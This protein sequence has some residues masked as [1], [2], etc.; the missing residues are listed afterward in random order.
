MSSRG[1]DHL[2][3]YFS[4]ISY[5]GIAAG[6]DRHLADR[7]S[8]DHRVLYVDP[9][10]S[11]LARLRNSNRRD[12]PRGPVLRPVRPGLFRCTPLLPPGPTRAGMHHVVPVIVRRT[13]RRA[14]RRLGGPVHAVVATTLDDV[15]GTVPGA[16][17][18]FYG[19]D[20]HVAGAETH[21]IPRER[22]SRAEQRQLRRADV[23][24]AVSPALVERY[25]AYG[26]QAVLVPNGCDPA[27]HADASSMPW[28]ADVTLS[29]PIAGLLGHIGRRVD[30]TMLEAVA[31]AGCPLL[32]IGP[33]DRSYE[34]VR[35]PALVARP[36][37]CWVGP[38]HL[39]ELPAYL[40]VIHVGLTPYADS[41]LNRSSFPLKTL[42]YI[43]A[44]A[45]VVSTNIPAVGW[46]DTEHVTIAH[47]PA[48]FASAVR[49]QLTL[50]RSAALI[51]HRRQFA[52]QHSWRK[53][54]ADLAW[55]LGIET[56]QRA[57]TPSSAK[58]S[59]PASERGGRK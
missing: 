43:A 6:T 8:C 56:P 42:E 35:F 21:G 18:L 53:R 28:P 37:V 50:P 52:E 51:T 34:P 30:L 40:R 31:D 20:D 24:A 46:L 26:R 14:V 33:W 1:E 25:A 57:G 47:S 48:E 12:M 19:T 9:P 41:D 44:G 39:T 54:A 23:I 11:I 7:L 5:D 17:T 10:V 38:K 49:R 58:W 22:W 59:G 2:I 4:S 15:L 3:I 16:R 45:A 29:G 36:N 27:I 32:L 55:L 13:V